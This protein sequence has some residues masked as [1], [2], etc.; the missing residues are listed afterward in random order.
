MRFK[1][2]KTKENVKE[3]VINEQSDEFEICIQCG[4]PTKVLK[5]T[6]IDLRKG[7]IVGC[8]QLCN[9]CNRDLEL[10]THNPDFRVSNKE[11]SA[12]LSACVEN[13]EDST[14]R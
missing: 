1:L 12:L 6:P 13:Q 5:S 2:F 10:S 3:P 8:G 14:A 9:D 4:K 7:F 11:M